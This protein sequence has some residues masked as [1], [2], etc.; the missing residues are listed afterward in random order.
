VTI[1]L[2]SSNTNEGTV[3][4]TSVTFT[5]A[6]ALTPQTVTVTGNAGAPNNGNVGYTIVTGPAT[7]TD[8]SFSGLNPADVSVTNNATVVIPPSATSGIS[9]A[10]AT[11][12]EGLNGTVP[13]TFTVTLSPASASAVT[14]NYE[15]KNVTATADSRGDYQMANGTLTFNPGEASKTITV[16]VVAD[17]RPNEPDETFLV[18]LSNPSGATL[19]RGQATGTIKDNALNASS[20]SVK[21]DIQ[22]Q[23]KSIS[24]HQMQVTITVDKSAPNQTNGLQGIQFGTPTNATIQM[25]GQTTI[26]TGLISLTGGPEQITFTVTQTAANAAFTVPFKISDNCSTID[27]FVGGGPNSLGN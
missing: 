10:D 9:I 1:P 7:S 3:S 2:S 22:V 12:T 23:T 20:C 21:P 11:A 5:P 14:V 4:P 27:K 16:Q 24:G 18:V 26:G 17:G 13:M 15:T 19:T 8:P 6:N 25:T